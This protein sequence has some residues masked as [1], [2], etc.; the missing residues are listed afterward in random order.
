MTPIDGQVGPRPGGGRLTDRGPWVD[1]RLTDPIDGQHRGPGG[2]AR[3]TDI[4]E[5]PPPARAHGIVCVGYVR[6]RLAQ[7]RFKGFVSRTRAF[8]EH[9][10]AA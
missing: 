10:L 9:A 8:A 3:L 7:K 6:L 5:L 2:A 4:D 1:G